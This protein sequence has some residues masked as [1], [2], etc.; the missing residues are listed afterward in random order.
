MREFLDQVNMP[1]DVAAF[2]V[3]GPVVAGHVNT[4]NLP[5]TM[6][7]R[8]LASDLNLRAVH[9]L[10]DLQAVA[11][12]VPV[13]SAP[14]LLTLNEGEPVAAGAVAVI[15]PG[16]GLGESFLTWDGEQ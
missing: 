4:T 2:G 12:S 11:L 10:N 14:D 7:E 3:A 8:S 9:L 5:W 1:V 15:A 16:T 6:N 13:L